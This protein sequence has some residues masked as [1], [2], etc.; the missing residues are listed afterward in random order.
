MAVDACPICGEPLERGECLW[1]GPPE[2][3]NP[4]DEVTPRRRRRSQ[5][6][7]YLQAAVITAL[8]FAVGGTLLLVVD[9][10]APT[11]GIAQVSW[12]DPYAQGGVED[13]PE[14]LRRAVEQLEAG[15]RVVVSSDPP[16]ADVYSGIRKLGQ[17]PLRLERPEKAER[18]D[19]RISKGGFG[20][21]R[22]TV[23]KDSPLRIHVRLSRGAG[24]KEK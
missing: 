20:D 10:S 4:L 6:T 7:L 3:P 13:D 11:G 23:N 9:G 15:G 8:V 2:D 17:T 16:G 22:V 1:H 12:I 18:M 14:Q 19:L 5:A 24:V 21:S